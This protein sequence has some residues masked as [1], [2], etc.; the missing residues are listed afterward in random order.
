MTHFVAYWGA[1]LKIILLYVE[2]SPRLDPSERQSYVTHGSLRS[3]ANR[4]IARWLIEILLLGAFTKRIRRRLD[5]GALACANSR[6]L[7]YFRHG[8][9]E[10]RDVGVISP[11]RN[12]FIMHNEDAH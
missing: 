10:A 8:F 1:Q 7:A 2:P 9:Y 6:S 5:P 11:L 12:L 3:F 4:R